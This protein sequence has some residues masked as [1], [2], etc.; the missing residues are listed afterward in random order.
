MDI[1]KQAYRKKQPKTKTLYVC[2]NCGSSNVQYKSWVNANTGTCTDGQISNDVID[3]YCIDCQSHI[4][5][6]KVELK[7]DA[8]IIGYQVVGQN[9]TPD[10]SSL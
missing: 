2:P 4:E 5:L 9:N 8:H 10:E 6:Q 1:I 7:P 3:N